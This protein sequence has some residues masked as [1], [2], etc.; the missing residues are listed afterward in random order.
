MKSRTL[1]AEID[2]PNPGSQLLPG[3]YAYAKVIIERPERTGA[4]AVGADLQRR[5]VPIAGPSRTGMR[6]GP[7]CR[8]G[9]ATASGSRSPIVRLPPAAA[10]PKPWVPI[11]GTEK[12]IMGDLTLLADGVP[13][14]VAPA[15]GGTKLASATATSAVTDSSTTGRPT[16]TPPASDPVEA[17]NGPPQKGESRI[18]VAMAERLHRE[19]LRSSGSVKVPQTANGQKS[20]DPRRKM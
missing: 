4:A 7:K 6:C 18:L 10:R 14:E 9:S 1:R 12:V 15:T 17:S 20:Q 3:M 16:N 8:P 5:E 13:V 19:E 11:D 2:L